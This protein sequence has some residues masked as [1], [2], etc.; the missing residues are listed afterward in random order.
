MTLSPSVLQFAPLGN[1]TDNCSD[2][3]I[4]IRVH[5][6]L[7]QRSFVELI[8]KNNETVVILPQPEA[9][10]KCCEHSSNRMGVV[11][12]KIQRCQFPQTRLTTCETF[13][14]HLG[15]HEPVIHDV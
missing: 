11:R 7:S 10:L 3:C 13:D 8:R 9:E 2:C 6:T 15:P 12:L 1:V 14:M 5:E 4:E